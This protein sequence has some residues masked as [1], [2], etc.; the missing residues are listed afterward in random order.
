MKISLVSALIILAFGISLAVSNVFGSS[1]NDGLKYIAIKNCKALDSARNSIVA[2]SEGTP[3]LSWE[4][5]RPWLAFNKGKHPATPED[6]IS[7]LPKG[8]T[9]TLPTK[10]EGTAITLNGVRLDASTPE[11]KGNPNNFSFS[12]I[13]RGLGML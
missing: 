5:L 3:N 13:L 9:I 7:A 2:T 12:D 11:P 1:D 6:L 8:S 10:T 4:N